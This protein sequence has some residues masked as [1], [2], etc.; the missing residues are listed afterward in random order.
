ML[1]VC[2]MT[3]L[4]HCDN[5]K[6]NTV[7]SRTT[8][9]LDSLVKEV[10][11]N[12]NTDTG[13]TLSQLLYLATNMFTQGRTTKNLYKEIQLMCWSVKWKQCGLC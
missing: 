2:T 11:E 9:H 5:F 12:Y 10:T 13:F 3:S 8:D 6:D 4:V 1:T 7:M